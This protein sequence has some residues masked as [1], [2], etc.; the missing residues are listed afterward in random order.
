MSFP[1]DS[2]MSAMQTNKSR[3]SNQDNTSFTPSLAEETK[4]NKQQ[5]AATAKVQSN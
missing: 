3:I 5:L 1:L 4:N 2:A